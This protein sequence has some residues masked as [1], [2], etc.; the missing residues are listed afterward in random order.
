M[1]AEINTVSGFVLLFIMSRKSKRVK[2][3][4][5]LKRVKVDS[6]DTPSHQHIPRSKAFVFY[7]FIASYKR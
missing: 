7:V 4:Q 1:L 6:P 2:V 5:R 3:A